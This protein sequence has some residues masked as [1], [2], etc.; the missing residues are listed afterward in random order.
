VKRLFFGRRIVVA[1]A[2][3]L[4][5][6]VATT[7][8]AVAA[9]TTSHG[10]GTGYSA[11]SNSSHAL[12]VEVHGHCP[13]GTYEVH[14]S[15]RGP[16]GLRGEKGATGATG[17]TGAPGQVG[18]TGPKGP[19]GANGANGTNGS[20]ILTGSGVPTGS[21]NTGDSYVDLT[22]TASEPTGE[23]YNCVAATWIDSGHT[24]EGPQGPQGPQG[25]EGPA[26]TNGNTI[27]S[28]SGA[29]ANNLGNNGDFYLDTSTE[30]LYGP[31]ANNTW[32]VSG[33]S[34]VGPPAALCQVTDGTSSYTDLQTAINAAK[35]G[36]TLVVS[37]ICDGNFTA[38]SSF[39]IEG[40]PM[41]TLNGEGSGTV[42]TVHSG[43][44]VTLDNLV[45]TG[46]SDSG[47]FIFYQGS[48]TLA[49]DSQVDGNIAGSGGGIYNLGTV[50]LE[51]D[52]QVD[53]NTA[54]AD[55]GGGIFNNGTVTLEGDSQVDGNKA[56]GPSGGGGIYNNFYS[57]V[58]LEGDSQVDGNSAIQGGGIENDGGTVITN[59]NAG[60]TAQIADN[61]PGP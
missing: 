30:T 53:G 46:G 1:V 33:T 3:V 23:V 47:I 42:F 14:I 9:S 43:D 29:P 35:S 6:G 61:T 38:N 10:S 60:D 48:V 50:T 20:S 40:S 11:C 18:A 56:N 51:G 4:V 54:V 39:T 24:I 7:T 21:C 8:L 59:P 55:L 52:S 58:T 32:P 19:A 22:Y 15:A 17:P 49:G 26:G 31:K 12:F 37:G 45:I 25:L 41:A 44:T 13:A 36:D 34:L 16:Q 5:A 27:L 2:A 57:T 28:G